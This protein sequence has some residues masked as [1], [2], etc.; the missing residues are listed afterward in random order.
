MIH[1]TC[2]QADLIFP[3][4]EEAQLLTGLEAP[5]AIAEF[6]LAL[7]PKVVI[8]KMGAHGAILATAEG[9][10]TF[11]PYPVECR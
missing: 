3:S 4:L 7:G 5:H 1:E 10:D 9:I 6:Y 2:R 11:P 8:L